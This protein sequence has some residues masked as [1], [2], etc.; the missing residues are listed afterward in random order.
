MLVLCVMSSM[1][2]PSCRCAILFAVGIAGCGVTNEDPI[3]DLGTLSDNKSD[4]SLPRTVALELD[5]G[6]SKRYRITTPAF[7]ANLS[8]AE[9][10]LAQLKA[11]HLEFSFASD[12]SADPRVDAE[13]DGT[14][15]NWTLTV[16]NRGDD[17]LDA[18]VVIDVPR[19]STELGIVSDIDKTVLPPATTAGLPAPYPGIATL[20]H[21]LEMRAGGA[22]GDVHYV[23][24]RAP[25]D[26][27]EIPA[28]MEL[29][30]VPEGSIDTGISGVP[31]V[32][33]P[34]KVRD[35]SRIFEASVQQQ[36]VLFGD[37]AHRDP[38]VYAE[39]R[40]AYPTRVTAIF[41]HKVNATVPATRVAGMH[42]VNNYAE[43]AAIA[44]GQDLLTEAE[45]RTVMNAARTEGLA[46]TAAEIDALIDA[47]R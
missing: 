32:A 21:T 27:V 44:F 16:Y 47:A 41:I 2:Y 22:A 23:T 35:I 38:E 11:K 9:D 10:V 19:D 24:A 25:V 6:A 36:F 37:T 29:H 7:V 14:S 15:R 12:V 45:A 5:P 43:A 39:I 4:A 42:L 34:E 18:T 30:G 28:W 20:L 31:W 26:V 33:Q 1:G 8:Q 3:E 17:L 40:T 13:A 46:I